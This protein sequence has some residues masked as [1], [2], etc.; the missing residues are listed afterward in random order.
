MWCPD[1][2]EVQMLN[3]PYLFNNGININFVVN[4]CDVAATAF[5]ESTENC[6]TS[7]DDR[8]DVW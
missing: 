2:Q 8:H 6:L 7:E 1:T 3:N 5:N 4:F